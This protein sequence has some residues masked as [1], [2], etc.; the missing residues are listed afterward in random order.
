M[1]QLS[2]FKIAQIGFF[3]LFYRKFKFCVFCILCTCY[4]L[5]HPLSNRSGVQKVCKNVQRA[6]MDK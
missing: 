6:Y 5:S 4:P 3:L 1:Q 2:I